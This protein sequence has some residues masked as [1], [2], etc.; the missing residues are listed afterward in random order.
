MNPGSF[1]SPDCDVA[2]IVRIVAAAT[3]AHEHAGALLLLAESEQAKVSALQRAFDEASLHLAGA[4]FP[5]L[6]E[7][8]TFRLG[9]CCAIPR[10]EM[11]ATVLLDRLPANADDAAACIVDAVEPLIGA[12]KA[13]LFLIFDAMVGNIA[14]I[15]DGVYLRLADRVVYAG[16]NAGSETFRPV[17]CLFDGQRIVEGGVLCLVVPGSSG[18]V[19]D[20]GYIAPRTMITATGTDG[21]R[22][23]TID[24]RPAFDVYQQ[25]VRA[26]YDVSLTT[27]NFYRYATHFPFGL[28]LAND[29]VIVRIPVALEAD[30]SLFCIGEV[31]ANA[32]LTLLRAPERNS[33]ATVDRV[34]GLLDRVFGGAAGRD[35]L[36][37]YCAG[38]RAHLGEDAIDELGLLRDRTGARR[39]VGALS[40]GEIGSLSGWGYPLFHNGAMVCC[41]VDGQWIANES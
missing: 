6:V 10:A 32:M 9:G 38:R 13:T 33:T 23:M 21:N 28:L 27:E 7:G 24:W 15:L 18:A 30:G 19:L 14:S 17:P 31:P 40:L 3:D 4:I 37:F 5:A 39:L 11:P 29:E 26:L 25:Q 12:G 22:I 8:A 16:V 36:T 34:S 41:P 20:H 2:E 35:L 1:Y